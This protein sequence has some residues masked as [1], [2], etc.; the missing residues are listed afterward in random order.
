M[1]FVPPSVISSLEGKLL[2]QFFPEN[3]TD[4][5]CQLEN[6]RLGNVSHI[7]IRWTLKHQVLHSQ[8]HPI[9]TGNVSNI[10]QTSNRRF[11]LIQKW[12]NKLEFLSK[13]YAL[14]WSGDK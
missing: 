9:C 6:W 1:P 13:P 5:T 8:L 3:S 4:V 7:V 10:A 2:S 14:G 11:L 12:I